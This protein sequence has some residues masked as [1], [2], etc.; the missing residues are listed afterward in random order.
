MFRLFLFL[1]CLKTPILRTRTIGLVRCMSQ[2]GDIVGPVEVEV[3]WPLQEGQTEPVCLRY[4][5]FHSI[6][7]TA[8][9]IK[10]YTKVGI[11]KLNF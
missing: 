7:L 6:Y 8:I 5:F 1:G 10:E 2:I 3:F 11:R 4:L 9:I